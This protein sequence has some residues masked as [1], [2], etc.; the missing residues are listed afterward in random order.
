M[1]SEEHRLSG[2]RMRMRRENRVE[3]LLGATDQGLLDATQ[4]SVEAVDG[5]LQPQPLVGHDLLVPAAPGLQLAGELGADCLAHGGLDVHVDVLVLFVPRE[6]S[7]LDLRLDSRQGPVETLDAVR[8]DHAQPMQLVQV[9]AA[10]GDVEA[11]QRP[12]HVGRARQLDGDGGQRG[13]DAAAPQG[14]ARRRSLCHGRMIIRSDRM[15]MQHVMPR[16]RRRRRAKSR[17]V[18]CR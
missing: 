13:L 2:L 7:S 10:G 17:A 12:I 1:V 11:C 4:A 15:I 5:S 3:M 16:R 14:P 18:G 6:R 9:R 8:V